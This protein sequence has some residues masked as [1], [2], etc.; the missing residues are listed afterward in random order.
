MSR[1]RPLAVVAIALMSAVV[2]LLLR[3]GYRIVF[4]G[5]GGS[6]E[7]LFDI[8]HYQLWGVF[9]HILI[10]G[11]VTAH[12]LLGGVTSGLPFAAVIVLSGAVLAWWDPRG[13]ILSIPRLRVGRSLLTAAVIAMSTLPV[14]VAV[15]R[16]TRR[17]AIRRRVT[18]GRRIILPVLEKTLEHAAGIHTALMSRGV[19]NRAGSHD[20]REGAPIELRG[21][22]WPERGILGLNG[23]FERGSF[24]IL[25]GQTGSG[26]TS[27][28]EVIV[29]LHPEIEQVQGDVVHVSR[30]GGLGYLPHRP[31]DLFLSSTVRDEVAL[32]LVVNGM[33]RAEARNKAL[34]LLDERGLSHLG[35]THPSELSAGEAVMVG[36]SVLAAHA[37]TILVLDEPLRSLDPQ[38]RQETLEWLGH[39]SRSGVT[40]IMSDHRSA[41]LDDHCGDFLTLTPSGLSTGRYRSP[42]SH[43]PL[44]IPRPSPEPDVIASFDGLTASFGERE[45]F[46]DLRLA[47]RRGQITLLSGHN[48]AGKTTLLELIADSHAQKGDVAYV[49][50]EPSDL[51]F[52]DTV[53]SE[54]EL[55]DRSNG[56]SPGLTR[57]TLEAI[58]SGPWREAILHNIDTTHP[59]D[60]S[61]GQQMALAVAIQMSQRPRVLAL[62]EPTAGLDDAAVQMLVAVLSCAMETGVAL[63]IATQEPE[64]FSELEGARLHLHDG[65][66][67]DLA[68]VKS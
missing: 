47:M 52:T 49:P 21:L 56:V 63:L 35:Q 32:S 15:I 19:I 18:L 37:P 59:R 29:G 41:E 57:M 42:A 16:D 26:K 65:V 27:L 1:P 45:V 55:A 50:S 4:G 34:A 51:F 24:S 17:A 10:G 43:A 53:G 8:P 20:S 23:A 25:T 33:P 38:R 64:E 40:V 61:R 39:L 14:L 67:T 46:R 22:T 54:L 7:V 28:L 58:L 13:L 11:E 6:G 66:L 31:H 60:L 12:G 3:V 48:G 2:F 62:D 36:L 68:E 44:M 5:A 30:S 9:S